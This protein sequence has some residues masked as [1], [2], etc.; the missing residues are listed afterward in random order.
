MAS[1]L[2]RI[3]A[4][5]PRYI[6]VDQ[7]RSLIDQYLPLLGPDDIVDLV[8]RDF[9]EYPSTDC[10]E[11]SGSDMDLES[12]SE[13][14][15]LESDN[16]LS[17]TSVTS[18]TTNS[19]SLNVSGEDVDESLSGSDMDL[20]SESEAADSESDDIPSV[21]TTTA[22]PARNVSE[23]DDKEATSCKRDTMEQVEVSR[24]CASPSAPRKLNLD[25][26]HVD[27]LHRATPTD[28]S[29]NGEKR[30]ETLKRK[31]DDDGEQDDEIG[32]P[33]RTK[34]SSDWQHTSGAI[35]AYCDYD[36]D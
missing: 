30:E 7:V 26:D 33:K 13:A 35:F 16:I 4:R 32:L 8:T 2:R 25:E 29:E 3:A 10:E 27:D 9:L 28:S 20:E 14:D 15:D 18:A 34:R 24:N 17:A 12:E 31:L 5:L 1:I 11:D 36:S 6:S 21:T 23:E 22:T 19:P